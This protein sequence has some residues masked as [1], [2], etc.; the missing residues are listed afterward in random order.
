MKIGKMYY[1]AIIL[2]SLKDVISI[3]TFISAITTIV[4]LILLLSSILNNDPKE[5]T[6]LVKK[7]TKIS[8]IVLSI[9]L[10][11]NIITPNKEDFLIITMTKDYK[12]EQV[13]QMTKDE[14]KNSIDYLFKQIKEIKE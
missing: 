9:S 4:V 3:L 11:F 10:F 14:I 7:F 2:G 6:D 5:D 12:P 1:L 13:Y 8:I